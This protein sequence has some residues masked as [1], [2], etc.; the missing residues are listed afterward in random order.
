MVADGGWGQNLAMGGL[1][2]VGACVLRDLLDKTNTTVGEQDKEVEPT[3]GGGVRAV[4]KAAELGGGARLV[5]ILMGKKAEK[6]QQI[7]SS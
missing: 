6:H 1:V 5:A 2:G 3:M 7:T 4:A